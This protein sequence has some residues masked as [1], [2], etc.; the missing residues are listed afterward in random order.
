M[1]SIDHMFTRT[2]RVLACGLAACA[3]T[4]STAVAVPADDDGGAA[5]TLEPRTDFRS[6]DT[7][8]AAEGYAPKLVAPAQDA[9]PR[10]DFRSPDT[11]DAAEGY[12]PA[13]AVERASEAGG[14]DW[15]T[16]GITLAGATGL[17]LVALAMLSAVRLGRGRVARP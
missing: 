12:A 2:T 13:V 5:A 3:I 11:R 4:A 6:P 16:A 1:F 15:G 17:L 14:F 10:T 7:R 9:P 8:D